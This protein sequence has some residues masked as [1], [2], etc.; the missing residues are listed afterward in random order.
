MKEP[1]LN[2]LQLQKAGEIRD[3]EGISGVILP[4]QM[5]KHFTHKNDLDR[6]KK[7]KN[8]ENE[9]EVE[10]KMSHLEGRSSIRQGR[11]LVRLKNRKNLKQIR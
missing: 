4:S 3:H 9:K 11:M 8:D 10:V 5:S 2:S 6:I 1:C 7:S